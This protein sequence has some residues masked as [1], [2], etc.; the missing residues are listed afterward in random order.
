M[1]T[2]QM[3]DLERLANMQEEE[4]KRTNPNYEPMFPEGWDDDENWPLDTNAKE[5][6]DAWRK[7][8]IEIDYQLEV[9][10]GCYD[11]NDDYE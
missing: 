7:H 8:Q 6:Y 2:K 1:L 4:F 10:A 9:M 11:T 5:A 3:R